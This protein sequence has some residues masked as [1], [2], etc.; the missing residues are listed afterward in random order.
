MWKASIKNLSLNF[1]WLLLDVY[2]VYC[3]DLNYIRIWLKH[4]VTCLQSEP[5]DSS[6]FQ[7]IIAGDRLRI[8]IR[9]HVMFTHNKW[10]FWRHCNVQQ[11]WPA[12]ED[13]VCIANHLSQASFK[14][15]ISWLPMN[16]E[17]YCT[18]GVKQ[19]YGNIY[20]VLVH[21]RPWMFHDS[22]WMLATNIKLNS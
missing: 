12:L 1:P 3:T 18:S 17:N 9:L 20:S 21:T 4:V 8:R 22:C 14:L 15:Q 19:F 13:D 7:N 2:I 6:V 11:L 16:R 10:S 5:K